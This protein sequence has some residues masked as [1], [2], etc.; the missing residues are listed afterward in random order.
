MKDTIILKWNDKKQEYDVGRVGLFIDHKGNEFIDEEYFF[1]TN[2]T[3]EEILE[4]LR[5]GKA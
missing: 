1:S 4:F 5:C 3:I 2:K